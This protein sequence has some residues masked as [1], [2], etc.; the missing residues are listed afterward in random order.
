MTSKMSENE[1]PA[2]EFDDGIKEENFN[3]WLTNNHTQTYRL[4]WRHVFEFQEYSVIEFDQEFRSHSDT[5][6][7]FIFAVIIKDPVI[8]AIVLFLGY[9]PEICQPLN[10]L[11]W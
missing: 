2:R 1:Y 11:K 5:S 3:E 7:N 9:H 4:F 6:A 10:S 8:I